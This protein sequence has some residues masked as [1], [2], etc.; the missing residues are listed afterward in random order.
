MGEVYR[1]EELTLDQFLALKF[2]PTALSENS[3][4]LARFHAEVRTARQVSHPNV[5]RMFDIG[6]ADGTLFLTMDY[7]DGEDL[8]SVVRRIG[9]LSPDKGTEPARQVGAGRSSAHQRAVP[10]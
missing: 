1:A 2:L 8:P 5:S 4:A 10:H 6:E 3:A 9:R 7:V